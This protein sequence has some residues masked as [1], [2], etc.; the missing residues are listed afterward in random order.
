MH[1]QIDGTTRLVRWAADPHLTASQSKSRSGHSRKP[2][3]ARSGHWA[4]L[5]VKSFIHQRAP[6]HWRG[7]PHSNT[8]PHWSCP[9]LPSYSRASQYIEPWLWKPFPA[10]LGSSNTISFTSWQ[11]FLGM[12]DPEKS[13]IHTDRILIPG[14]CFILCCSISQAHCTAV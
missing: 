10:L 2:F 8:G 12:R 4:A 13:A 5:S 14:A 11:R 3:P 1:E 6:P 7:L 9:A